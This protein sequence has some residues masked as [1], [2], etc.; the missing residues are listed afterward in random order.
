M[1]GKR[2]EVAIGRRRR[3]WLPDLSLALQNLGSRK[4]RSLLTMMGMIFGVAAVVSMLSIGAGAQQ[5]V[6]AFIEQLGVRNLIV[7][8][9]L[10]TESQDL[11]AIR[12]ISP[13]LSFKDLRMIRANIGGLSLSTPRKRL[14]PTSMLPKPRQ[15]MPG[16]YGVGPEYLDIA[17][18]K[19]ITG[20]YFFE[21]DNDR[22]TS[23]CVLGEGAKANLF[24]QQEAVG[25]YIKINDQWF[26]VIGILGPQLAA[27]SDLAGLKAQDL[28]NMIYTPIN[29]LI[30][31][32]EER[33]SAYRDEIDGIFLQ[34]RKSVDP[35]VAADVIRSLLNVTH[36]NANDFSMIV[37]AELLA[38]QKRTQRIFEMVMVAIASISLLVGGIGIMNIMLASILER[39]H[40]IGVRRAVG[41]CRRDILRQFL[42]E[43]IFI[44]FVGGLLGVGCGFGLSRLVAM[45]A[46]WST[47]VTMNS[48]LLAFLVSVSVGLVFG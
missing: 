20:R 3:Q 46:G 48:I 45:M 30:Y 13:G 14:T 11:L 7:E 5:Q 16:V 21:S 42:V 35:G 24:P 39:T 44:S 33:N 37:P 9:K 22:M 1:K 18:L 29:S 38:E 4:L 2:A 8:A 31:R 10:I 28:N 17:R 32:L 23:V 19:V 41:A 47:I 12:K 25:K 34:L 40:E 6:L 43:A 15:D 36:R 27:P 26:C